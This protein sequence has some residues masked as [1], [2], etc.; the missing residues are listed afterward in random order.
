M[1]R[2]ARLTR[3]LGR[4]LIDSLPA[5]AKMAV[6]HLL[7]RPGVRS[8]PID[9]LD[10]ELATASRLFATS[11]D[12][13]R[14]FLQGL[15]LTLATDRPPDPF[16]D[17]YRE[18]TWSLYRTI[19][20]KQEYIVDNE[21]SPF[22]LERAT[23]RPFPFE[24]RSAIVVGSD[25]V[26][27]GHLLRC[28]GEPALGLSPPARVVEFGPGWGNLTADLVATGFDVTAVEID[29]QFCELIRRR[30]PNPDLLSVEQ[31]DMLSF[32]PDEYYDAAIFFE[33][34]HHCSDHLAMLNK[35][36]HIVRPGGAVFFASEP[37]QEM[38]YPWGPR[39][40]G[41][42]IWSTRTYG[43]LELGF[44]AEYF[45]AALERTGWHGKRRK[46]GAGISES[47]VIVAVADTP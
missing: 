38:T 34:F 7:G 33:S 32:E 28:M 5:P 14:T 19:S 26:A 21:T 39:L 24:T 3:Q 31:C 37:V 47:D 35:L 16:S 13:A 11:E 40:D 9:L 23:L 45:S 10:N 18:W 4:A 29:T 2:P 42:S 6:R 41:L 12:D 44:D 8:I 30:C 43:W 25:L 1:E 22:D 20:G 27:R 46:V 15:Q 17:A 36:H